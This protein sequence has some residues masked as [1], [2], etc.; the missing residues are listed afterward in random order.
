M[1]IRNKND[2]VENTTTD[3]S[4]CPSHVY[5]GDT[6]YTLS[7]GQLFSGNLNCC[8]SCSYQR[9][10]CYLNAFSNTSRPNPIVNESM[11]N[12]RKTV[13]NVKKPFDYSI[14][15]VPYCYNPIMNNS[16]QNNITKAAVLLEQAANA[17]SIATNRQNQFRKYK[18]SI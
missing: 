4:G 5:F 15:S 7:F 16:N 1:W 3:C 6:S 10:E 9:P 12:I 2:Q 18:P 17:M 13:E 14:P 8:Q 11:K